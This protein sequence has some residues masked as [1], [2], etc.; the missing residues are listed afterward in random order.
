MRFPPGGAGDGAGARS[1]GPRPGRDAAG[2][3][4]LGRNRRPPRRRA[5]DL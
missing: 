1:G 3:R 2:S 4:R 5:A